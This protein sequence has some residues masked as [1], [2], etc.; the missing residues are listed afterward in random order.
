MYNVYYID[1]IKYA[2]I[3]K[4]YLYTFGKRDYYI[5]HI[6]LAVAHLK[7]ARQGE[8]IPSRVVWTPKKD[9]KNEPHK[10]ASI[11][12]W[13]IFFSCCAWGSN[14]GPEKK[15]ISQWPLHHK[16]TACIKH[17]NKS[18]NITQLEITN[19]QIFKNSFSPWKLGSC[20]IH[21]AIINFARELYQG[22]KNNFG[23]LSWLM[24]L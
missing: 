7:M 13:S 16:P 19:G 24:G 6:N 8:V 9:S 5:F 4:V 11:F 20:K 22:L 17:K 12:V 18:K 14:P 23:C 2:F 15:V 1:N 3:H 21:R 10:Q